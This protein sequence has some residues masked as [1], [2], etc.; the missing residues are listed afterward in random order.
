MMLHYFLRRAFL[1]GFV[2]V[3]LTVL[4][5]SL[6]Y[7]FPGDVLTNISGLSS[8]QPEQQQNLI[9][10]YALDQSLLQQYI[11]YVN[12]ILDGEWGLSFSSQQPVL[13]EIIAV[14]PATLELASYALILSFV[15]GIPLGLF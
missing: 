7:L 11:A 2:F 10:Y 5:F 3:A 14:F 12:R 4:A 13:S 6:S 8:I 9:Q 1:I 15:L